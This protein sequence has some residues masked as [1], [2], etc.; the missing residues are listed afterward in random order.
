[1]YGDGNGL[2]VVRKVELVKRIGN[3]AA[4][5]A[6]ANGISQTVLFQ[7]STDVRVVVHVKELGICIFVPVSLK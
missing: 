6:E 5:H 7:P 4:V 2:S 1:M 3:E